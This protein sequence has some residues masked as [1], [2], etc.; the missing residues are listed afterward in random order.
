VTFKDDATAFC[1]VYFLKHKADVFDQFVEFERMLVNKFD[2]LVKTL[3]A[4]NGTE[5]C[6]KKLRNYLASRG[7]KMENTAPYIPA[8]NGRSERDNR[9]IVECARTMLLAKDLP[10]SL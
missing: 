3:R 7:I 8:Q 10:T 6:N 2:R 9:T 5:Y 1:Y 4:D